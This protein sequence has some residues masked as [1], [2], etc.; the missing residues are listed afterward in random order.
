MKN[1]I[2]I[3]IVILASFF[4]FTACNSVKYVPKGEHLLVKN[5]LYIDGKN[6]GFKEA[7][8]YIIQRPN[9]S[10]LL[11]KFPL[12]FYNLGNKGYDT[13]FVNWLDRHPKTLRF[14]DKAF[15]R[16]QVVSMNNTYKG[17]NK[18]F[19][20]K[21]EA[22]VILDSE[23][24]TATAKNLK[25][26]FINEGYYNVKIDYKEILLPNK[27]A[28]VEYY[29]E[30]NT[31]FIIDSITR[32]I[33]SHE[34][35][36]IYNISEEKPRI[37][38]GDLLKLSHFEAE[39]DRITKLFRNKGVYHFDA[40]SIRFSVDTLQKEYHAN[41]QL[42]IADRFIHEG[43]SIFFEPY[44]T[45]KVSK[46]KVY[47]DYYFNERGK[48]Y[49]DTL[50]HNGIKYISHEKSKY[51]PKLLSNA[52]FIQPDS[53]YRD[54]DRE[55]TRT[56]LRS[57]QNFKLIDI[58]YRELED[59][60]LEASI[61]LTPYEKFRLALNTELTHSNIRP[62]GVSGGVSI[63]NRNIFK[64]A[65]IIKT[66]IQGSFLNSQDATDVSTF[67]NAWEVG[68]DI[69]LKIPRFLLP[70]KTEK[71]V[72]K[73]MSPKTQ[74]LLATNFQKNIGLDKQ[75]FTGSITYSWT[76]T[77]KT[78]HSIELF[79]LQYIRNL[80]VSSYFNIYRTDY[81]TLVGISDTDIPAPESTKDPN[82]NIIP[83]AYIDYVLDPN[84]NFSTQF[85]EDYTSVENIKRRYDIIT[86]DYLI[87]AFVYNFN[88][89]N[90]KGIKDNNFSSLRIRAA[91]AGNLSSLL[92]K[93][94]AGEETKELLGIPIAQYSKIDFEYRKFWGF[95]PKQTLAYRFFTGV[96]IPYGNSKGI[97]FNKA[98]YI[99]GPNDLRAW[100]VYSLGPGSTKNGL[101]Y[102]VGNFKILSSLEYRFNVIGSFNGAFFIDAG[103]I[104]DITNNSFT[105]DDEKFTGFES[106]QD[107]AIGSGFGLR[108][109]VNFLVIRVDFGF[110]TY[111][112]YLE[113]N[114]WFTNYNFKKSVVN[115]GINYPF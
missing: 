56:Q 92:V 12:Y 108:Y 61:F 33:S 47:T 8:D 58:R 5:K 112:P 55:N 46:V 94:K 76:P 62:F 28:E 115:I 50:V 69:S 24:T 52:I 37:K 70:F 13:T 86:E 71:W 103:N 101:E 75:N 80:N 79:N 85:P 104:W 74:F 29:I 30:K 10:V 34:L 22:P 106:L 6:K 113:H 57:L 97:P 64:G 43:D 107:I 54:I 11:V 14:L 25:S 7:H 90:S 41:I 40:N 105:P 42:Q 67:F 44:I 23:K 89:N 96:A 2:I 102:N 84:N 95:G 19:L 17:I 18:W 81:N 9:Q 111:E 100:R 78:K 66:S 45:Q 32:K 26:F 88:Y 65:E 48:P 16:K 59:K 49:L 4:S 114:R 53:L 72:S 93:K 87:P 60:T 27:K 39:R 15:S 21:G 35:D 77:S 99:G 63:L 1:N 36:S 38:S 20:E 91:T 83:L 82:G 31:P 109:D 73:D 3:L 98:Y 68:G 110:K 51:N